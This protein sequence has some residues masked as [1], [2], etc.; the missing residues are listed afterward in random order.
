VGVRDHEI[1]IVI[2]AGAAAV[3]IVRYYE[4]NMDSNEPSGESLMNTTARQDPDVAHD[5]DRRDLHVKVF[6]PRFPD[7][8]KHFDWNRCLLVS[9]AAAQAAAAFGYT[10]GTPGL[11]KC[12]QVLDP[13]QD[14]QQ[15]GVENGDELELL[16]TGGGV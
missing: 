16:D 10:G 11:S 5:H 14:L 1:E 3:A 13:T 7:E 9:E 8:P 15:A 4:L 12:R 6:A 2:V